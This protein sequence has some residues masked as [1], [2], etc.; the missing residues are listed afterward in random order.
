MQT[1]IET[2]GV[3]HVGVKVGGALRATFGMLNGAQPKS[4]TLRVR[5]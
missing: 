4:T 2:N 1:R 5:K 3:H